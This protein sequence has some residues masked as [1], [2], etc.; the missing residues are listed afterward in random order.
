MLLFGA[1]TEMPARIDTVRFDYTE[2][3]PLATD[4][5]SSGY[6]VL[7]CAAQKPKGSER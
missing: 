1:M 2:P 5:A 6:K 7:Y 4:R 3:A